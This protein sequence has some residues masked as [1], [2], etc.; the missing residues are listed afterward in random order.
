MKAVLVTR[1]DH[2]ELQDLPLP[3]PD[4]YQC[5]AKVLACGFCNGTDLKVIQG[6]WPGTDPLPVVLGHETVAEIIQVGEKVRNL[7]LGDRVLQARIENYPDLGINTAWGGFVEYALVTDWQ[8][9]QAD[10]LNIP[11]PFFKAQ[12]VIPHDFNIL[13]AVMLITLKEVVSALQGFGLQSGHPLMIFGDGPVG[14]CMAMGAR[15]LGASD[16][17]LG[18]HHNSRLALARE[19]GTSL[20]IN[21]SEV[22][23]AAEVRHHFPQGLPLI[24]DAVG[25][26]SVLQESLSIVAD[27]GHIGMYGF[28]DKQCATFDWHSAPVRWSFDYLVVP[29]LARFMAC[30]EPIIHWIQEGKLDPKR[31]IT[32]QVSIDQVPEMVSMVA[33]RSALKMVM[34]CDAKLGDE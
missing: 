25:S 26:P 9:M 32:H 34:V 23:V 11:N 29:Q 16:V 28:Y 30:H 5:L 6:H 21:S 19:L 24:V 10:G 22:S 4:P 17:I 15:M 18:G 20:T 1:P 33:D 13:D 8:A 27:E 7:K 31:L 2:V 3:T 14:L 12:Q